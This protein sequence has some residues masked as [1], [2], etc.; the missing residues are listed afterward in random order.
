[1]TRIAVTP[2]PGVGV[3]TR[4]HRLASAARTRSNAADDAPA[5]G[6]LWTRRYRLR[7]AVTDSIV[8]AL[9]CSAP[10]LLAMLT[11]GG[12]GTRQWAAAGVIAVVWLL[13]LVV[14]RTRE[15]RLL[16]VGAAEY[17]QVASASGLTF[18]LLA[19]A[20]VAADVRGIRTSFLL[21]M[22]IG[23]TAL[24]IARWLWRKWLTHQ[25]RFGH[26]LSRV[27]VAGPL[28]DVR[29]VV[30]QLAKR[31]G[32]AFRVV[33][34]AIDTPR[35]GAVPT[36]TGPVPIVCNLD[37]VSETVERLGADTVIVTD[38]TDHGS[39]YIRDLGWKLE[40]TST[41]LVVAS[42]LTNIAGPRIHLRPVEG[43]PLMHVEL[44]QYQ[45]VKHAM[46]RMLDVTASGLG[47]LVLLPALVVIGILVRLDSPGP[48]LFR[49]ERVGRGGTTFKML[50]FRSMVQDAE[51]QLPALAA[52][53]GN[54]G[55]GV[56]FKL[57]EDPRVTRLG[58]FLRA[59][60]IDE[61]PQ[62]WNVFTGQMSLVGPRPPL[63]TEVSR[64]EEHV[65][66]RL[67][68]KPGLTGMWQINGRSDLSWEES[69]RLDLYYV[70]NWS[71]TSDLVIL[72]RT[73]KVFIR[74]TGAY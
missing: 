67:Y 61:L 29:Y 38:H 74:P 56:L 63:P 31:T 46:K 64:Y 1:M 54:D 20:F 17:K 66:R 10:A 51:A 33:G 39:T 22:L 30:E 43:L 8:V 27:I 24:I 9:S 68:I 72:W 4:A 37:T 41:E 15:A 40:G 35:L 23:T 57:K 34:V 55:A 62:L 28:E 5:S 18:G 3:R 12:S 53:A 65:Q 16:G 69:V 36:S 60:S 42:S 6:A 52:V 21:S 50:K 49:Q 7:L 59:T 58:R 25:R 13:F 70:E 11:T 44:P 71:L 48:A 26:Y 32:A 45:G 14:F 2:I 73:L 47:L 19:I